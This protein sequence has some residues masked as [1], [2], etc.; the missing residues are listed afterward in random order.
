M[1]RTRLLNRPESHTAGADRIARSAQAIAATA[2]LCGH[3][4]SSNAAG[5]L[6]RD[7][8]QLPEA[9]LQDALARCR[10]ELRGRLN[11][12]EI[13]ARVDDG[14]PSAE[15]AWRM[16]P[17]SE[18]ATVVWTREMA[19]A[20]G[21][22]APLL[23]QGQ[24]AAARA[25]FDDAYAQAVLIARCRREPVCWIASL[26]TDPLH[27]EQVLR[28]AVQ[29]ERLPAAYVKDLLPYRSLTPEARHMLSRVQIKPV[30]DR[31]GDF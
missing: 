14:R 24:A 26:G 13:L 8:A 2:E 23:Q 19:H 28:E 29:K 21:E 16:M 1:S 17:A 9:A 31:S 15:Q 25:A 11:L 5:M 3:V 10:R 4:L 22:A 12:D 30:P 6:A 7:L 18:A 27:R 20:W